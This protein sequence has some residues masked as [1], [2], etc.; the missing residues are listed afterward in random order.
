MTYKYQ[1]LY[2]SEP[3]TYD[4]LLEALKYQAEHKMGIKEHQSFIALVD[5]VKL[6]KPQEITLPNGEWGDCCVECDGLNY[7]CS[8]IR[9]IE[10]AFE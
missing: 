3:V 1:L 4:E 9:F 8:T 6:H 5:I 7:P 2:S 10:K